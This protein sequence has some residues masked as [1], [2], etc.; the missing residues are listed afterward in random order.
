AACR[1]HGTGLFCLVKTSN[2]GG[3]DV[4]DLKLSDGRPLWQHVARMVHELGGELVGDRGLSSVGG[5]V[6]ATHPR[7]VGEARRLMPQ[8][9]LLGRSGLTTKSA[10]APTT[11]ATTAAATT[12]ARPHRKQFYRLKTGE[13]LSDVAIR[14]DTTV[15]A[16]LALNPG[17]KV[18]A[19]TVGQRIRV[20]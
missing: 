9:V 5:V 16:L 4:Q 7:A 15:S 19:L 20:R 1:R 8:A 2:E 12:T 11:V 13:T 14:F 3:A 10:Q 17:I 6:G 18:N